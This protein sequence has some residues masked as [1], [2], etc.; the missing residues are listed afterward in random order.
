MRKLEV[1][2]ESQGEALRDKASG[3]LEVGLNDNGEIVVNHPDLK[4]DANGVGHIVFSPEQ[5]MNFANLLLKHAGVAGADAKQDKKL[6]VAV[7]TV[8]AA[9]RGSDD[10]GPTVSDGIVSWP[11]GAE[12]AYKLEQA[13]GL[14]EPNVSTVPAPV[15]KVPPY[16][17]AP[18]LQK[19]REGIL[20][21]LIPWHH[22][23]DKSW[24]EHLM[25]AGGI[26]QDACGMFSLA[27]WAGVSSPAAGEERILEKKSRDN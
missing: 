4:P 10:L 14:P 1:S 2:V 7:E 24:V 21:F 5:A 22:H 11:L 13:L 17:F 6:R 15:T 23:L 26:E 27:P 18:A 16:D 19:A 12:I 9:I 20:R 3:F 8:I 25:D